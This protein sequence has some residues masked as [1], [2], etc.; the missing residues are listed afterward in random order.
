MP[1]IIRCKVCGFERESFK[2]W[3]FLYSKDCQPANF[4]DYEIVTNGN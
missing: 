1:E 4:H 3:Q 2:G